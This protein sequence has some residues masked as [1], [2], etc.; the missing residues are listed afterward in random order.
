[1]DVRGFAADSASAQHVNPKSPAKPTVVENA[2]GADHD[3]L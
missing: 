2:K 1:M 3:G